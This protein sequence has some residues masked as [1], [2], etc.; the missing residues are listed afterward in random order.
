[1]R[2]PPRGMAQRTLC[3]GPCTEGGQRRPPLASQT[4]VGGRICQPRARPRGAGGSWGC[5][6]QWQWGTDAEGDSL[7]C[8]SSQRLL[9]P[10]GRGDGVSVRP[11]GVGTTKAC[12]P[13]WVRVAPVHPE[14][15]EA[16]SSCPPNE[17][18]SHVCGI[19][20][21]GQ[22]PVPPGKGPAVVTCLRGGHRT[23]SRLG[24]HGGVSGC[25][26]ACKELG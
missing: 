16:S 18:R 19:L 14:S 24:V 3:K 23:M 25:P 21:A 6:R 13:E 12:V 17:R 2:S 7:G 11:A 10:R 8:L 4:V 15:W 5:P 1:M 26:A 9:R 20:S 22:K